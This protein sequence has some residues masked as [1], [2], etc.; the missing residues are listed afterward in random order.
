M[1]KIPVLVT[2][3]IRPNFLKSV[4]EIIEKRSDTTLVTTAV[5]NSVYS[6]PVTMDSSASGSGVIHN[7]FDLLLRY[8][9]GFVKDNYYQ[10]ISSTEGL[11]A[12]TPEKQSLFNTLVE[13]KKI[14]L[15]L[16]LVK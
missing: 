11:N 16:K 8:L 6:A 15:I 13:I 12:L 5:K 7:N 1:Q 2:S 14:E 9:N 4:L 3:F 10:S